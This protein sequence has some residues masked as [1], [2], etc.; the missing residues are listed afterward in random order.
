MGGVGF[1]AGVL[2]VLMGMGRWQEDRNP[3][4]L[5]ASVIVALFTLISG[6]ASLF[7]RGK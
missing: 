6:L 2:F 3:G 7:R 1:V 5:A 4:W